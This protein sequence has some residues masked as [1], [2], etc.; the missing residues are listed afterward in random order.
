M[1]MFQLLWDLGPWEHATIVIHGFYFCKCFN[2]SPVTPNVQISD[3]AV[4]STPVKIKN[5][6][7]TMM[8]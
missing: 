3:R 1:D 7:I 2:I 5:V 6:V 4:S 8:P